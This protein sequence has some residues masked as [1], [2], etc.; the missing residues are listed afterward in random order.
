MVHR[1][2]QHSRLIK[3][4]REINDYKPQWVINRVRKKA[5]RFKNPV[6]GCMGLAFKADVD[7]LRESPAMDIVRAL[8][9]ENIGNLLICEPNIKQHTDFDLI[10]MDDLIR[11]SDIVLLLVDHKPFRKLTAAD[12]KEKIVI[13][14][15]GII[16]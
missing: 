5:E 11:E 3:T 4:A 6:I 16:R 13:D 10:G 14:T 2:P 1:S 15:R 9:A 8:Q 7:D 12:L